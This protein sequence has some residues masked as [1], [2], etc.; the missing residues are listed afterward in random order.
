MRFSGLLCGLAIFNC[1]HVNLPF[2][3]LMF[4]KMLFEPLLLEDLNE[5]CSTSMG[6][7]LKCL[8]HVLITNIA[9]VSFRSLRPLLIYEE[10]DLEDMFGIYFEITTKLLG[11]VI[12][13]ELKPGGSK[14][15]V[16]QENKLVDSLSI[17]RPSSS[18]TF[19]F[20]INPGKSTLT[21]TKNVQNE[22]EGVP[23]AICFLVL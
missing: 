21:C 1:I 11:F 10:Q 7:K 9:V 3:L 16:T 22:Y 4:K 14:I 17:T 18:L 15:T 6:Y 13:A 12:T 20:N 23:L 2:P 8:F 5:L 19:I